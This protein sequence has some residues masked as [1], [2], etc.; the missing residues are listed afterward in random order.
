MRGRPAR[1]GLGTLCVLA[2]VGLTCAKDTPSVPRLIVVIVVDQMRYDY[3]TRFRDLY[4]GGFRTLLDKGA[5]FTE[6][7][8][9]H[10]LTVT[11]PGHAAI[12]TGRHPASSG[13]TS[14]NWFDPDLNAERTAVADPDYGPVGGAGSGASPRSLLV[15]TFGDR[16]K[17]KNPASRVV[18]ISI[19][20]R[21]AILMAGRDADAA[22]WYSASCGCFVT[23]SYYTEQP[24]GWLTAFNQ[25]NPPDRFEGKLW[26]RLL[27]DPAIYEKYSRADRFEYEFDGRQVVFPHTLK[28]PEFGSDTSLDA[29][30][31]PLGD[32][33]LLEATLAAIDG[34]DL[35]SDKIP[36]LLAVGFSSPDYVG[37][38]FGPFSQ[39][40]MD[41]YLRLDRVLG[42]LFTELDE[43]VG[44]DRTLIVLSSDH[45]AAPIVEEAKKRGLPART[46]PARALPDAVT[47]AFSKRALFIGDAVAFFDAPHFFLDFPKLEGRGVTRRE[48]EEIAREALLSVDSV[49]AVYTHRDMLGGPRDDDPFRQ[50]YRNSF[51]EPRGPHLMVRLREHHYINASQGATGHG[52]PH[53]YDRH[54]PIIFFGQQIPPGRHSKACG[55]EDIAPTLAKLLG[56]E[57]QPMVDA[58]LLTEVL[59]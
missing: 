29:S 15:D 13:I 48:A 21:S 43:R 57:L 6:A 34:H 46:V 50:L 24:P 44:L 49:A 5:V 41:I 17:Q 23:S 10:A 14:N 32:Q 1:L 30:W 9:R 8:F 45:G 4:Q 59:Q 42:Q 36:D 55:P 56:V 38:L 51:F 33:I 22:Y 25:S 12:M 53:D 18:G 2:L 26:E 19:K 58:R 16:L 28:D 7:R 54:I 35:G 27:D 3:L 37:H 20:D 40:A 39:E 47:A 11:A 31:S 52:T